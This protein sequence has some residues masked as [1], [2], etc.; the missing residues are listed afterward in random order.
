MFGWDTRG[1]IGIWSRVYR[2]HPDSCDQCSFPGC[3]VL[4]AVWQVSPPLHQDIHP[5]AGC[6]ACSQGNVSLVDKQEQT[7]SA[8]YQR[9]WAVH[10]SDARVLGECLDF[11]FFPILGAVI[12]VMLCI[13]LSN[14]NTLQGEGFKWAHEWAQPLFQSPVLCPP[15][16]SFLS[17]DHFRSDGEIAHLSQLAQLMRYS[18][19]SAQELRWIRIHNPAC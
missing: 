16:A 18:S 11:F 19:N 4:V 12:L 17:K 13:L 3:L 9:V 2:W 8:L 15:T 5:C 10:S 14:V 7:S 6:S 1:L